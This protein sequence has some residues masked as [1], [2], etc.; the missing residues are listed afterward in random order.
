MS[1]L[2]KKL[3]SEGLHI[4]NKNYIFGHITDLTCPRGE[5]FVYEIKISRCDNSNVQQFVEMTHHYF[6]CEMENQA[7]KKFSVV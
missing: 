3:S 4:S 7:S 6:F 5:L 1:F 2:Q